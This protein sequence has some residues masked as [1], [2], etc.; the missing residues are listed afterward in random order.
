MSRN[1][2]RNS[3]FRDVG[4]QLRN[5]GRWGS[6]DQK[7]TLNFITPEKIVAATKLVSRGAV[8]DLGTPFDENGPY[9]GAYGRVNPLHY[10]IVAGNADPEPGGLQYA[11]DF[12]AMPLQSMT[13]WDALSHVWYDDV[14]YNGYAASTYINERGAHKLS[15]TEAC[16]GIIGRGV[17]LDA[18]RHF[19]VRWLD[20]RQQLEPADLDAIIA[21]QA[22]V[23][24]GEGDILLIRTGY[25]DK[26]KESGDGKDYLT[27]SPGITID[28]CQWL[29]E[30]RIAAV[31]TDTSSVEYIPPDG[32]LPVHCIAIRDMG[33]ILGEIFS[34]T[35]LADDCAID[36][37]WE[38][39]FIGSPLRVSRA[40]GSPTNPLAVK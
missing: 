35:A 20:P 2:V 5:W 22:G 33:M 11:D 19:G 7:G 27:A 34:L 12:I 28:C 21:S 38:F 24:V 25:W 13:Q 23:A 4:R 31:A 8:F 37:I 39:L 18:P 30:H 32:A 16:Q 36:N 26:F 1:D 29:Y 10:M 40:V 6:D 9:S 3:K 15:I 17:L 14:L